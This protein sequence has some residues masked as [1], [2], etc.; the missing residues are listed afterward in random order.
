MAMHDGLLLSNRL[1]LAN[2]L[3]DC[4]RRVIGFVPIPGTPQGE[5]GL[6]DGVGLRR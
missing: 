2:Q 3:L 4:L 5:L 1:L 6:V